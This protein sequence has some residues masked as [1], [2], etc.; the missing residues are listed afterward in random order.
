MSVTGRRS[1]NE[2]ECRDVSPH[3]PERE[4]AVTPRS[5]LEVEYI[6]GQ[7]RPSALEEPSY[8]HHHQGQ[9]YDQ[10]LDV[11]IPQCTIRHHRAQ[12][13]ARYVTKHKN[14]IYETLVV[15]GKRQTSTYDEHEDAD[16]LW[17]RHESEVVFN[18]GRYPLCFRFDSYLGRC[19]R[20]GGGARISYV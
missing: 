9:G 5:S 11:Q 20:G 2:V 16:E 10:L 13:G 19:S 7:F 14:D 4:K 17:T 15:D 3:Q 18:L 8:Q 12:G 6:A 1:P